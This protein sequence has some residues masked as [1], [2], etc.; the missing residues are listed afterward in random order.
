MRR[1][2]LS[3]SLALV[4]AL[5]LCLA[6][7]LPVSADQTAT[8]TAP[9]R[10]LD[11]E[12]T[13]DVPIAITETGDPMELNAFQID[14]KV[15]EN[16]LTLNSASAGTLISGWSVY[17]GGKVNAGGYDYWTVAGDPGNTENVSGSGELL[18]LN[19]TANATFTDGNAT[20]LDLDNCTLSSI[21]GGGSLIAST[22]VD[23]LATVDLLEVTTIGVVGSNTITSEGYMS[24][25]DEAT[26]FTMTP[27]YSGGS[28]SGYTYVWTLDAGGTGSTTVEQPGDVVYSSS[29]GKTISLRVTDGDTS[30]SEGHEA[31][32]A[33]TIY[34]DLVA[35]FA[36]TTGEA[37]HEQ[38]GIAKPADGGGF[39]STTNYPIT[40]TFTASN[41]GGKTPYLY[42][43]PAG[44]DIDND[45]TLEG[46][47]DGY[48][49][50]YSANATTDFTG[51]VGIGVYT[52]ELAIQD[53]LL[54]ANDTETKSDY[55]SI[56]RAGNV[57]ITGDEA[58]YLNAA[59]LTKLRLVIIGTDAATYTSDV[60][61]DTAINAID[62]TKLLIYLS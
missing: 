4:L 61:D 36:G 7:A 21:A 11:E 35:D 38:E 48:A 53:S 12:A 54:P 58:L 6:T 51:T 9:T 19:F 27:T 32:G 59:D 37:G 43:D 31:S 56:Y 47:V 34:A 62:I 2:V 42:A 30:T 18:V 49:Y 24:T 23:G 57:N 26:T 17:H 20:N 25:S 13:F 10:T 39:E 28:G 52:V 46:H 45:G 3:L 8:V 55:I 44:W 29:G 15:T 60:N 5:S 40:V 41:T 50:D 16:T 1:K 14:I 22:L 33:A